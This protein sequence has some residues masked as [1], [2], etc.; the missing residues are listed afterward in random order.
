MKKTVLYTTIV[1]FITVITVSGTYAF[2][3]STAN[4]N[5]INFNTSK[6]EVIYTGG[7]AIEGNLELVKS[8][9]EGLNTTVN[10]KVSEGSTIGKANLYINI[11]EITSSIATEALNWEVYKTINDTK[12]FVNSGTFT[13]CKEKETKKQCEDGDKLYIVND[14]ELSTTNTAFTVYIW[15]NGYK[16]GN[17]VI[18][19]T[20]KAYI[21]AE[22]ENITANLG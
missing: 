7:T 21:G 12:S 22:S 3:T 17:E 2:L 11:E 8:K 20:L 6:F 5:E 9:E 10:I 16:A 13:D 14:Y 4:S 18:G 15:L 19:S 1:S